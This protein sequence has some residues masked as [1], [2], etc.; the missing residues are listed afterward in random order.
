MIHYVL[1]QTIH[2]LKEKTFPPL[3]ETIQMHPEFLSLTYN[4][5]LPAL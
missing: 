3:S 5:T 4:E 1:I 2:I